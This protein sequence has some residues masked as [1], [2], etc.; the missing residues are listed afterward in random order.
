[1]EVNGRKFMDVG[2]EEVCSIVC[3]VAEHGVN[4]SRECRGDKSGGG[5]VCCVEIDSEFT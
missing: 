2:A 3:A 5:G 1:M 4:P